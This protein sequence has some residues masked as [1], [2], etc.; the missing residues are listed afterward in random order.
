MRKTELKRRTPMKRTRFVLSAVSGPVTARKPRKPLPKVNVAKKAKRVAANRKFYA[1]A[2]WKATRLA[3]FEHDGFRCTAMIERTFSSN[4]GI[5]IGTTEVRCW[6]VD[7]S[8]TGR[9]LVCDEIRYTRRGRERIGVDTRTLCKACNRRETVKHRAN[10][11]QGFN[12]RV[13]Q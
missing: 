10:H 8:R 1:S 4:N 9:G 13:R 3:T 2:G 6:F 12:N 5:G 7:E 11:A